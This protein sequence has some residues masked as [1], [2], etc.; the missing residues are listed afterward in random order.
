M[1]KLGNSKMMV[2]PEKIARAIIKAIN[3]KKLKTR[4]VVGF[5]GRTLIFLHW[6]LPTRCYDWIA[7]NVM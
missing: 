3:S 6:I 5:G 4:Y 7:K 2:T 1:L